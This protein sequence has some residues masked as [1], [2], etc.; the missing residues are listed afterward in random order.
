MTT[1]TSNAE[2]IAPT[3][4]DAAAP[5]SDEILPD[6]PTPKAGMT[7]WLRR[8]RLEA[9]EAQKRYMDERFGRARPQGQKSSD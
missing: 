2:A 1:E 7:E 6:P 8:T 4:D 9:F 3:D 5:R